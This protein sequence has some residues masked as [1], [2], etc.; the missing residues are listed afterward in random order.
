MAH[1]FLM[2]RNPRLLAKRTGDKTREASRSAL[3]R[4]RRH[5]SPP[6]R[7]GGT[8][9]RWAIPAPGSRD[10][11]HRRETLPEGYADTPK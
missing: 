8:A 9:G 2:P 4:A 6:A 7:A 11:V 10:G 3:G 1:R 5:R